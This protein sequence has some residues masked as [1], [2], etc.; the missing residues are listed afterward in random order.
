MGMFDTVRSSYDLGP[1]FWMRDLQTKDLECLMCEYW[2]DPL[3]QLFEIDYTGTQDFL[4]LTEDH[5]EYDQP[6]WFK[7]AKN[8][9]INSSI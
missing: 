3:G 8:K 7:R 5:P 9:K 1:G 4:E 2:I 6:A